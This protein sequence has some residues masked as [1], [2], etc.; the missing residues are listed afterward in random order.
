[1]EYN[2][3]CVRDEKMTSTLYGAIMLQDN[4][5][6]AIRNFADALDKPDSIWRKYP[7]DFSLWCLGTYYC[8]TGEIIPEIRKVVDAAQIVRS[9]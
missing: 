4:D 2:I 1:M 6:V 3:Y 7:S 5:D 9:E 8:S